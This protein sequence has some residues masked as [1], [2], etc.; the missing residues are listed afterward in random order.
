MFVKNIVKGFEE[1]EATQEILT[2]RYGEV[3]EYCPEPDGAIRQARIEVFLKV[4][5][6]M[7]PIRNELE[8]AFNVFS[9]EDKSEDLEKE[10]ADVGVIGKI[11]T[12]F[13]MVPQIAEFLKVRNQSLL[14]VA[15][16]LRQSLFVGVAIP[17]SMLITFVVIDI[18]GMTLNMIVLFS[19]V[20]ALGMLVDNAVV[21]V[22]NI[23]RHVQEGESP[24][25]ASA[26]ATREVGG[27]IFVSTLTTLAAFSPLLFWPGI[28][29]DF[30]VYMPITVSIALA[31]SLLVA[32]TFNPVLCATIMRLRK[33]NPNAVMNRIGGWIVS[34]YEKL[35][36]WALG[37][38]TLVV[39]ATFVVF[40][41]VIAVFAK[42]NHGIE[43]FPTTEPP[44]IFIDLEMPPG[45]RLEK[46]DSVMRELE[47]LVVNV[48]DIKVLSASTGSGSQSD[49]VGMGTS[50]STQGRVIIDLLDRDDRS[51]SSYV[52]LEQVRT[53]VQNVPAASREYALSR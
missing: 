53:L 46:T 47:D 39:L 42:F 16:G 44:K 40:V 52:T 31:A 2:E 38:R 17:F 13:G 21:V 12:G 5:E 11:R 34:K 29:G 37:H 45:T 6:L 10:K 43:F 8:S 28:V 22:E 33:E 30:M 19:L 24:K 50:G 3:E 41:G 48:P 18:S 27:A 26:K 49:F 7:R 15:L 32:F 36:R 4:R 20:L 14:D 23:Y 35:L 51:Q 9:E 1:S 25:V